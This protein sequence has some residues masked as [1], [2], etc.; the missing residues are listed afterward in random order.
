[1]RLRRELTVPRLDPVVPPF[2]EDRALQNQTSSR[3]QSLEPGAPGVAVHVEDVT[4][5]NLLLK[6]EDRSEGEFLCDLGAGSVLD[7]A[8]DGLVTVVSKSDDE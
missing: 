8:L 5:G 3:Q 2:G 4:V 7:S 1:L 6:R